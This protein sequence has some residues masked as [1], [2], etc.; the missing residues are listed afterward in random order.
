NEK[1]QFFHEEAPPSCARP[2]LSACSHLRAIT[3]CAARESQLWLQPEYSPAA[4]QSYRVSIWPGKRVL[5]RTSGLWPAPIRHHLLRSP[6]HSII[7]MVLFFPVPPSTRQAAGPLTENLPYVCLNDRKRVGLSAERPP[8]EE[9][10]VVSLRTFCLWPL[11]C[12][13]S[14]RIALDAARLAKGETC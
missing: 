7:L 14:W 3:R 12:L 13:E 2:S 8:L 9:Q 11:S 4:K 1:S 5:C 6:L 10:S